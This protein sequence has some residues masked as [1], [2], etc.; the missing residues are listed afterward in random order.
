[1]KKF[2]D[3]VVWKKAHELVLDVYRIT[4]RFPGEER[5]ALSSQMRRTAMMVPATIVEGY[6]SAKI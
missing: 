3:L 1:M 4:E 6:S 5:A 2:R